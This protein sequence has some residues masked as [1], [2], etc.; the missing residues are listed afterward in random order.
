MEGGCR[1]GQGKGGLTTVVLS[2]PT[3]GASAEVYLLGAHVTSFVPRQGGSDL[4]F[5]SEKA[6][7]AEGKAIRGGIP[8]I[9]PQFSD[10]GPLVKHGFART[11]IWE[12]GSSSSPADVTLVLRSSE[13]TKKVWAHDFEVLYRVSIGEEGTALET[14]LTV[15]NTGNS[16]FSFTAA[17][18]TYFSVQDIHSTIVEGLHKGDELHYLDNCQGRKKVTEQSKQ[19][20]F[21]GET[22]RIYLQTADEISINDAERMIVLVKHGLADAVVWNA[23][24]EK[25]KSMADLGDDEWLKFVCVEAAAVE[26]PVNLESA[27]TWTGRQV[28]FEKNRH[29][30]A[31]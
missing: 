30:S 13:K 5:V 2:Q 10:M 8:V 21:N 9:F 18:H 25:A 3:T 7:F 11:A 20:R 17:L 4:L 19:I 22:D 29:Q 1:R 26:H 14:E 28:I 23:W 12:V 24:S 6:E 31:L 15:K 16:A 27:Q